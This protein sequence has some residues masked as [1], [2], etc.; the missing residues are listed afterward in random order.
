MT[1]SIGN[2]DPGAAN[3]M[4]GLSPPV[5]I[6]PPGTQQPAVDGQTP[7]VKQPEDVMLRMIQEGKATSGQ[8]T[9][10]STDESGL[11]TTTQSAY[12]TGEASVITQGL[13]QDEIDSLASGKPIIGPATITIGS[14]E[15]GDQ[16]SQ[17]KHNVWLT[18]NLMVSVTV[19]L[20]QMA[21][22]QKRSKLTEM[23]VLV[24]GM[25]LSKEFAKNAS[26]LEKDTAQLEADKLNAQAWV[27]LVKAGTS[28]VALGVGAIGTG[29]TIKGTSQSA[30]NSE[31]GLATHEIVATTSGKIGSFMSQSGANQISGIMN[32]MAD[33]AGGFVTSDMTLKLGDLEA[34]KKIV[35][36]MQQVAQKQTDSASDAQRT[37]SDL[38]SKALELL[39]QIQDRNAQAFNSLTGH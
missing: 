25:N 1:G 20:L 15:Q 3:F 6:P 36:W 19:N 18:P 13:T 38:L 21:D 28:G 22:T 30:F 24:V 4:P 29:M 9:T 16:I 26:D 11:I 5:A 34:Q 8:I 31:T 37:Q 14:N 39:Q 17:V 10:L 12:V 35:A 32:G 23:Q 27:S 7:A 2:Q 33:A